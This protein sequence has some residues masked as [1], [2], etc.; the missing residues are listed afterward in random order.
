MTTRKHTV[1]R[2]QDV[3]DEQVQHEAA[4]PEQAMPTTAEHV[5]AALDALDALGAQ[6]TYNQVN[7]LSYLKQ[8]QSWLERDH[9]KDH[10]KDN[11]RDN[12]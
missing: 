1:S 3:K 9:L 8:A 4:Q 7:A 6:R 10:L 12:K 11:P 2:A 5:K